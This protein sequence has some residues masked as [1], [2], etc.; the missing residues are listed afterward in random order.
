MMRNLRR[1]PGLTDKERDLAHLG[2]RAATGDR[3][4]ARS[5]R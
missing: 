2:T 4:G 1:L 5:A 3:P